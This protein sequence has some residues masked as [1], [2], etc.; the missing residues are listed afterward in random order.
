M[1]Q[2]RTDARA[3]TSGRLYRLALIFINGLLFFV[4]FCGII[5]LVFNPK[6]CTSNQSHVKIRTQGQP[7]VLQAT[8]NPRDWLAPDPSSLKYISGFTTFVA[9]TN[10]VKTL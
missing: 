7:H 5:F 4:N 10:L 9:K 1:P 2:K 6:K 8:K 3:K